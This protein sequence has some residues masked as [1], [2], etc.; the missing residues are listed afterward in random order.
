ME[1]KT[2]KEYNNVPKQETKIQGS[3]D[4][5]GTFM[6]VNVE[7]KWR[8]GLNGRWLTKEIFA[9]REEAQAYINTK[10]WELIMNLAG[11]VAEFTIW[12]DK[13]QNK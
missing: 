7:D 9:S 6:V 12:N 10:P 11:L 13:Q 8:I 2:K 5:S 4:E 1:E 3:L